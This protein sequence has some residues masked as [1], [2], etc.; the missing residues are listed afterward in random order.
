MQQDYSI[1]DFALP[2]FILKSVHE[3]PYLFFSFTEEII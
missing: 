2:E 3:D 1:Q